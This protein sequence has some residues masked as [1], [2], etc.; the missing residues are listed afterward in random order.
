MPGYILA[1]VTPSVTLY[2]DSVA[3]TVERSDA[4][5]WTPEDRDSQGAV[6]LRLYLEKRDGGQTRWENA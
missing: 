3:W 5:V 4:E 1:L 6:D 2:W